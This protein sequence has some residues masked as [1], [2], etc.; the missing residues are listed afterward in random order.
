MCKKVTSLLLASL[1]GTFREVYDADEQTGL[2]FGYL[3]EALEAAG[4]G[5]TA[6]KGLADEPGKHTEKAVERSC[7]QILPADPA[8]R[9]CR[10][11][12]PVMLCGMNG[13]AAFSGFFLHRQ[14][15]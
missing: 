12:L 3:K 8:G 5:E 6:Q 9:F 15:L 11:I 13:T 1:T 10:Q 4:D 14:I 2:L 7:R